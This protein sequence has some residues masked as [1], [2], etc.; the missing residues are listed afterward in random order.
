MKVGPLALSES[1]YRVCHSHATDYRAT[2]VEAGVFPARRAELE[3]FSSTIYGTSL[4]Q[5]ADLGAMST[6]EGK[7][8]K[9]LAF[10]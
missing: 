8:A 3:I 10:R 2:Q 5:T 4:S 9:E 7:S 1:C 6:F